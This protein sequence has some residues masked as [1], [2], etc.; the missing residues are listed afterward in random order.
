M[1]KTWT[2]KVERKDIDPYS[3]IYTYLRY[4]HIST[5]STHIYSIYT[6]Q[7]CEEDEED[8]GGISIHNIGGV[9]IVIFVG[10]FLALVTLAAEY[11]YYRYHST[12]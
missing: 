4:L 12:V 6:Y 10:I 9:F 3:F 1:N 2:H 7:S 5:I 8:T 11:M